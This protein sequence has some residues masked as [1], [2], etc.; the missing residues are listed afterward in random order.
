MKRNSPTDWDAVFE[1]AK[2]GKITD[3]PA[4]VRVRCYNQIKRIEKDYMVPA[5]RPVV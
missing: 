5:P 1:N 2:K 3:I 4:D